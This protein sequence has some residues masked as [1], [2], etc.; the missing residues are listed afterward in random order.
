MLNVKS[1]EFIVW[2]ITFFVAYLITITLAG[3]FRAWVNDKLGDDTAKEQGYLSFNPLVHIDPFGFITLL[4]FSVGWGQQIPV[5]P[6]K[7][8]GVHRTAKLLTAYLSGVVAHLLQ[9]IVALTLLLLMFD[10]NI[11]VLAEQIIRYQAMSHI[12]VASAYP[13]APSLFISIAFILIALI[14]L[15]LILAVFSLVMNGSTVGLLLFA[16]RSPQSSMANPY[17]VI[18]LPLLLLLFFYE[19]LQD[20]GLFIITHGGYL[21]ARLLHIA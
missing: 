13:N 4:M 12:L 17:A 14:Y 7:L 6:Y 10:K 15:N 3:Y 5:N 19:P 16:E 2:F 1:A 8:G 9:A 21:L 20:M 18:G 11:V